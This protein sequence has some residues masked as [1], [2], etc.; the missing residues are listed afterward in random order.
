MFDNTPAEEE[1]HVLLSGAAERR[2]CRP[3]VGT[4][5]ER[6]AEMADDCPW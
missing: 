5:E 3:T 2:H 1:V 6:P 4:A